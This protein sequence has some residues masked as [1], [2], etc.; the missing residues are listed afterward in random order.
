ALSEDGRLV[1]AYRVLEQAVTEHPRNPDTWIRL[2][3]FEL[4]DLGLPR[5][6]LASSQAAATIDPASTR[7]RDL[8]EQIDAEVER[9]NRDVAAARALLDAQIRRQQGQ[10]P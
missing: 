1:D 7:L 4:D 3:Q 6:A 8:V 2:G 5:R 9:Q 10:Q